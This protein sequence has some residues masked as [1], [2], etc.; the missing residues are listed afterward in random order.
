MDASNLSKYTH[1]KDTN[2]VEVSS[3]ATSGGSGSF[4]N[5]SFMGSYSSGYDITKVLNGQVFFL[6]NWYVFI[7][8]V[9]FFRQNWS[10]LCMFFL[11]FSH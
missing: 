11:D 1:I 2:G 8:L 9:C 4:H 10:V 6:P 3:W 5:G 7:F